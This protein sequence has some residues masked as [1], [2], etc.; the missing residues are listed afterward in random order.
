MWRSKPHGIMDNW[1][2][3]IKDV[4]TRRRDDVHSLSTDEKRLNRM[5]ELNVIEQV[6]SLSH[7]TIVQNAWERGQKL[8]I[9]GWIYGLEDGLIKDLDVCVDRISQVGPTY[10]FQKENAES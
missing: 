8:A 3:A 6:K 10:R 7:T 5:C 1:L 2:V 4:Y 9:Y